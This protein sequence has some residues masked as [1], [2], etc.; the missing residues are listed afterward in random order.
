MSKAFYAS[1][2]QPRLLHRWDNLIKPLLL[3][4]PLAAQRIKVQRSIEVWTTPCIV[5]HFG[6]SSPAACTVLINPCNP[7]LSGT[8]NFP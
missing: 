7:Q 1:K 3:S 6:R 8:R 4:S 2:T 5:N